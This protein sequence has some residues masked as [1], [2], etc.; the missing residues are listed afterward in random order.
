MVHVLMKEKQWHWTDQQ[1][2][3]DTTGSLWGQDQVY[4]NDQFKF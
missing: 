4:W 3:Y 2:N 1:F